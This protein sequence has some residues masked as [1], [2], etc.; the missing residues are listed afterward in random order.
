MAKN[1]RPLYIKVRP[2]DNVAITVD[3]VSKGTEIMQ[4]VV[5][6]QDIPRAHK[7]A[8]EDIPKDGEIIRYGVV[9]GY[10]LS[11]IAKGDWINENC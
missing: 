4:G 2:E 5:A 11:P 3:A 1:A 8:L 6:A 10:A 9:L 7:I